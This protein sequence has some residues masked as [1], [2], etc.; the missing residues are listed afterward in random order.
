MLLA[1]TQIVRPAQRPVQAGHGIHAGAARIAGHSAPGREIAGREQAVWPV[2]HAIS[3]Q[4]FACPSRC[5]RGVRMRP[6]R[7]ER[8]RL[9]RS[10]PASASLPNWQGQPLARQPPSRPRPPIRCA[11]IR[12]TTR[13]LR[14]LGQDRVWPDSVQVPGGTLSH[15]GCRRSHGRGSLMACGLA[16]GVI[17]P[18]PVSRKPEEGLK[19]SGPLVS[20][21]RLVS[22][23]NSLSARGR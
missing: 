21:S 20:A 11:G 12:P 3:D 2:S 9:A 22:V 6:R 23:R 17:G 8:G 19:V 10:R 5:R 4:P 13:L 14:D 18:F 1:R 7:H 16:L 15:C